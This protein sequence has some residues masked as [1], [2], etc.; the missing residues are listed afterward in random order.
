MPDDGY[1]DTVDEVVAALEQDP[2]LVQQIAGNGHTDEVIAWLRE[3]TEDLD[4]T[5]YVALTGDLKDL[6]ESGASD[7]LARLLHARLDEP[8]VYVVSAGGLPTVVTYDVELEA[9]DVKMEASRAKNEAMEADRHSGLAPTGEAALLVRAAAPDTIGP[10]D[11]AALRQEPG[12]ALVRQDRDVDFLWQPP[13]PWPLSATPIIAGLVVWAVAMVLL[14]PVADRIVPGLGPARRRDAA[15]TDARQAEATALQEAQS[16]ARTATRRL[17]KALRTA[18][19]A[20]TELLARA[21]LSRDLAE[22][23]GDSDDLLE[24]IGADMLATTA[25]RHLAGRTDWRPCFFDPRHGRANTKAMIANLTVPACS[26]CAGQVSE[27]K[28]PEGLL[29]PRG[30]RGAGT[31]YWKQ[32]SVWSRTGYGALA[33]DFAD[34]VAAQRRNGGRR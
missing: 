1:I 18:A 32:A 23:L 29:V 31:S 11:H 10:G 24:V 5:V 28:E 8:G 22:E 30:Q 3:H 25:T 19:D 16:E 2:I 7:E 33:D 9:L 27:G 20:E 21:T 14:R 15:R 13:D 4:F 26:R 6:P 17:S 34:Q 12:M